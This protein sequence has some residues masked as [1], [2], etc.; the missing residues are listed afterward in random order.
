MS[1]R[2]ISHNFTPRTKANDPA[3]MRFM[4]NFDCSEPFLLHGVEFIALR[5]TGQSFMLHQIRKMVGLMLNVC[6]RYRYRRGRRF[7]FEA[8]I[9]VC[10]FSCDVSCPHSASRWPLLDR[11]FYDSY[12]KKVKEMGTGRLDFES[13]G[14]AAEDVLHSFK[15]KHI[16]AHIAKS[17]SV[18]RPFMYWAAGKNFHALPDGI[19]EGTMDAFS[20]SK[21]KGKG[22][23]CGRKDKKRHKKH[24]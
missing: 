21:R 12:D 3:S 10:I 22:N 6:E 14:D 11:L 20:A 4:M 24:N 15:M 1:G 18:R 7:S 19:K 5:V 13:F 9:C 17:V 16:Y 23:H 8:C 2:T